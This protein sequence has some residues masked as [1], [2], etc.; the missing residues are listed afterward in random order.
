MPCQP[1][2]S[3]SVFETNLYSGT[4]VARTP[5]GAPTRSATEEEENWLN[6]QERLE[7]EAIMQRVAENH[8][9]LEELIAEA[10]VRSEK[11]HMWTAMWSRS[12]RLRSIC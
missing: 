7:C 8:S 5:S 3:A 4:N 2:A 12:K 9:S 6:T 11:A 10:E 1:L